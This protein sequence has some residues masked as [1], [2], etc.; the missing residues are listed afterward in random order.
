[1]Q[2][3]DMASTHTPTRKPS[4]SQTITQRD[5]IIDQNLP[6]WARRS[7]PVVRRELGVFWKRL[8]PNL[9]R[10]VRLLGIQAAFVLLMPLGFLITFTLPVAVISIVIVP[11]ALVLYARVIVSVA[12][13]TS[14]AMVAARNFHT[15]DLLRVSLL[16]LREIILGKI[17][18]NLWKRMEDI[19]TILLGVLL[20]GMPTLAAYHIAPLRIE[21]VTIGIRLLVILGMFVLPVR[22]LVEPF[23]AGAL[24]VALGSV[25]PTRSGTVVTTLALMVFYYVCV[26]V[27]F[28]FRPDTV[29]VILLGVVIPLLL[30]VTVSVMA[31]WFAGRQIKRG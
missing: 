6:P 8:F 18:A 14:W 31:V 25:L 5:V 15:M 27:P 21:E 23:M 28:L 26:L 1:L 2:V 22:L 17:A 20:C 3:R 16:S 12:H 19:D 30:P 4:I 29:W 10:L 11:V 13:G 24:A 7:N 9:N